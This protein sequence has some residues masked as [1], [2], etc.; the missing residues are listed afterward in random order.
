MNARELTRRLGGDWHGSYGL[1]P[2]PGHSAIDRSVKVLD[3]ADGLVVH[4][5]AGEDWRAIKETW[6]KA[7]WL[8]ETVDR[9]PQQRRQPR[10]QRRDDDQARTECAVR[11][12]RA[13]DPVVSGDPVS[14]YL[15]ARGIQEAV[16]QSIRN[17]QAMKYRPSGLYLPAL[18]AAVQAG[19]RSI[20]AV[21]RTYLCPS[22]IGRKAQVATPKMAF[23]P[24]GDGAVR[25]AAAG[26]ILGLAEGIETALSAMQLFDVPCWA[27]LG[28]RMAE[29]AIPFTVEQ[30]LI[31]ADNGA[32]GRAAAEEAADRFTAQ[33]RRV[34]LR[35]PPDD[36][37]DWNDF[38]MAGGA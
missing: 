31:F 8:D 9:P 30:I 36:C 23:G 27:A 7:G 22:G 5:F 13:A 15:G 21:Q 18:V 26:K 16:P 28:R 20:T 1:V 35:F 17:A 34:V 38:V 24:L 29:V 12:W 6:K 4:S 25:L 33:G 14:V 2:G 11:M 19:D 10:R 37:G 3:G 32:Q